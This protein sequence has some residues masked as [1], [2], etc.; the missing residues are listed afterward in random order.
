MTVFL[1]D[2]VDGMQMV[3]NEGSGLLALRTGDVF[4]RA[5]DI[6]SMAEEEQM[7]EQ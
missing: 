1:P 7:P 5:G 3:G 4:W 6:L 2:V